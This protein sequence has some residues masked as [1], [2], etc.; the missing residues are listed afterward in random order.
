MQSSYW[1]CSKDFQVME[2]SS[3][4]NVQDLPQL[5]SSA[6]DPQQQLD[7]LLVAQLVA[8]HLASDEGRG[9]IIRY[10]QGSSAKS[11]LGEYLCRRFLSSQ[12][13]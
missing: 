11:S 12:A 5:L 2:K 13:Y 1:Y 3:P 8:K 6:T 10:F 9:A 7:S 4:Q